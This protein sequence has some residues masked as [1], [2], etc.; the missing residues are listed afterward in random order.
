MINDKALKLVQLYISW[1]KN[2]IL[3]AI[4]TFIFLAIIFNFVKSLEFLAF[5]TL[6]LSFFV[7]LKY[8][9]QDGLLPNSKNIDEHFSFKYIWM[10]PI[11]KKSIFLAFILISY[12]NYIPFFTLIFLL[13]IYGY[14]FFNFNPSIIEHTLFTLALFIAMFGSFASNL[15]ILY[16]APKHTYIKNKFDLYRFLSFLGTLIFLIFGFILLVI[17]ASLSE[18]STGPFKYFNQFI[19]SIYKMNSI[20]FLI[21]FIV[22]IILFNYHLWN[23]LITHSR[24]ERVIFKSYGNRKKNGLLTFVTASIFTLATLQLDLP[25]E[26]QYRVFVE[27]NDLSLAFFDND[28]KK[29]PKLITNKH[30]INTPNKYGA[31]PLMVA[32]ILKQP[33][34]I[35]ILDMVNAN[36][37]VRFNLKGHRFHQLTPYHLAVM[38]NNVKIFEHVRNKMKLGLNAFDLQTS[39]TPIFLASLTCRSNIAKHILDNEKIDINQKYE[40]NGSLLHLAI[41]NKCFNLAKIYIEKGADANLTDQSNKTPLHYLNSEIIEESNLKN[42]ILNK[43][44]NEKV[45][46]VETLH[47]ETSETT[48]ENLEQSNGEPLRL[49]Q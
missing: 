7:V 18:A 8:F 3:I 22:I 23:R 43:I 34:Y 15:Y 28:L 9:P 29:I 12:I 14:K 30:L 39:Y 49:E 2:K 33:K 1:N 6:I 26:R 24:D 36:Y 21:T 10:L 44:K 41:K 32:I 37:D 20:S 47:T 16:F 13:G 40:K 48:T 38:T 35:E 5:P 31:T 42:F 25:I 46:S 4:V 17:L 45:S 19:S 11:P 27:N